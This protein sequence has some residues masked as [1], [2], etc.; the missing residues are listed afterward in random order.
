M[1]IELTNQQ[2]QYL[3]NLLDAEVKRNGIQAAVMAGQVFQ[4]IAAAANAEKEQAT[5]GQPDL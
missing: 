1:Q 4:A 5:D 3:A 2:A